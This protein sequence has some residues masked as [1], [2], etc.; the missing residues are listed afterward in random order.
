MKLILIRHGNAED[1]SSTGKDFDRNL[2]QKGIV[3]TR[4]LAKFLRPKTITGE[5]FC[6]SA[7]RTLQTYRSIEKSLPKKVSV[8]DELY[9]ASKDNLLKLIWENKSSDTITIIGHNNG[10]SELASYLLNDALILSTSACI[11]LRFDVDSW[12]HISKATGQFEYQF[13]PQIN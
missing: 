9:L 12:N 4:V 3:Q 13:I 11:C 5:V 8:L 10:L 2:S 1:K 6:S 7:Q